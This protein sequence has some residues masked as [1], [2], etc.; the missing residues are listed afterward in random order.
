MSIIMVAAVGRNGVIGKGG[1]L[2]W[3]I[4][5]DRKHFKALTVGRTVIM[6]RRTYE[7]LGKPL[8]QRRNLVVTSRAIDGVETFPSL[9]AALAAAEG[10]V[11]L[12]GGNAI[13]AEGMAHA[14]TIHITRVHGEPEG[15]TVFPT[16]DTARFRLAETAP[17]ERGPRDEYGFDFETYVRLPKSA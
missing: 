8:P 11:A 5:S 15:D 9:D 13:Y 2:P 16:I 6:G 3:D 17:G 14:D 4:P 10:P 7:E 1:D 12:I